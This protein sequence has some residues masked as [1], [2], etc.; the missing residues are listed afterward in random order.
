M[1]VPKRLGHPVH[2]LVA[3]K[4]LKITIG[5]FDVWQVCPPLLHGLR[6]GQRPYI[7]HT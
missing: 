3:P 7:S 6:Y 4:L 5:G 1:H 2:V